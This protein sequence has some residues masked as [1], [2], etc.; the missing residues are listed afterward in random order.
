MDFGKNVN[1]AGQVAIECLYSSWIHPPHIDFCVNSPPSAI[2]LGSQGD[3]LK[4]RLASDLVLAV[5]E[6]LEGR[7]FVSPLG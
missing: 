1:D 7:Q 2:D 6:V 3:I 5:N 4:C